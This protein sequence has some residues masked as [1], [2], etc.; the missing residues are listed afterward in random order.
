MSDLLDLA[1]EAHGGLSRWRAA[2]SLSLTLS[3]SGNLLRIKGYLYR[4]NFS[5]L[6]MGVMAIADEVDSQ[7]A[8]AMTA[9][10]AETN[11]DALPNIA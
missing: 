9:Y 8:Q 7:L 5:L 2:R 4:V 10:V 6:L 3:M 11:V 1:I